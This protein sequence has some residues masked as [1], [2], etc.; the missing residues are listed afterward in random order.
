MF[1]VAFAFPNPTGRL[2]RLQ[3]IESMLIHL[4]RSKASHT[5]LENPGVIDRLRELRITNEIH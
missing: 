5:Q 1:R 4:G 2:I 3:M